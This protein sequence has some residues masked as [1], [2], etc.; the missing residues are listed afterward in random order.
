MRV[1]D[2]VYIDGLA[3]MDFEFAGTRL[4]RFLYC[5]STGID[6]YFGVECQSKTFQTLQF[7]LS[8][9]VVDKFKSFWNVVGPQGFEPWTL[10]LKVRCSARLSYRP[11]LMEWVRLICLARE[12]RMVNSK[13]TRAA[14]QG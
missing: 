6:T 13:W 12:K 4:T 7:T 14:F 5:W 11:T 2:N 8:D 3:A 10:G 9:V 1:A